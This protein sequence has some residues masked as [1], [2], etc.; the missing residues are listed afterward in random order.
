[1]LHTHKSQEAS[2]HI[3]HASILFAEMLPLCELQLVIR[4]FTHSRT[5]FSTFRHRHCSSAA[6]KRSHQAWFG[7]FWDGSAAQASSKYQ[8]FTPC[9]N[10]KTSVAT[11]FGKAATWVSCCR[12]RE[13]MKKSQQMPGFG[14]ASPASITWDTTGAVA[15]EAKRGNPPSI[16]NEPT[17]TNHQ[18]TE[19]HSASASSPGASDSC[20]GANWGMLPARRLGPNIST[21]MR[22]TL[23]W[24]FHKSPFA[25]QIC[26]DPKGVSLLWGKFMEVPSA[27]TTSL[28]NALAQ[29]DIMKP[30]DAM[31]FGHSPNLQAM[32]YFPEMEK[33]WKKC[34]MSHVFPTT[35]RF[36]PVRPGHHVGSAPM[37]QRFL[38]RPQM[39]NFISNF[40]IW[41]SVKTGSWKWDGFVFVC[42]ANNQT[43]HKNARSP[44]VQLQPAAVCYPYFVMESWI[45]SIVLA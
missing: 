11:S 6:S 28:A 24:A 21:G 37:R 12:V 22:H 8:S 38:T 33:K 36:A 7:I 41:I 5:L 39:A 17:L 16:L 31:R 14:H 40:P 2:V 26:W 44:G 43:N 10:W 29:F 35:P 4:N 45:G 18:F 27:D 3:D 30:C 13:T 32:D 23:W 20:L 9:R 34:P 15:T 1:M 25:Y 42:T 19:V